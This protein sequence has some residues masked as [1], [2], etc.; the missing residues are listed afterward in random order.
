LLFS[1]GLAMASTLMCGL[2]PALS[3][4]RPHLTATTRTTAGVE[5]RRAHHLLLAAQIA[6]TVLLL[7]GTGAAV[8]ELIGLYRTSLGYDPHNVVI[9]GITLPDRSAPT[10][11]HTEWAERATFYERLRN[12][13]ADVP[14]V[15]SVALATYGIPPQSGER[16]EVEVPGRGM[17][18]D[19][20]PI[21]Q[22]ISGRYFATMRIPLVRGRVW[23]DSEGAGTPHVAVIN[24][25]MARARWPDES[26]IG[27]RVRIPDYIKSPTYFRLAAPGSDGWF[28]II[29]VVGDTPNVGLHEPPAPSI[30]VPYTLM[31]GDAVNVILRTSRD[32]L[33]MTRSIRE[34]VRS[35]DPNQPVSV[36]STAE[37]ELAS[38]GWAR[39]RFVTWLLL[40]FAAFAL[41]LAVVG[42]YSVVSYSVSCRSREFAIRMALGAGRGRIVNAAVQ[43]AVLAIVAGVIAGLTLSVGLGAVVARWSI[44][45]LTDPVVLVAVS[46]VLFVVTLMSAAMPAN[47]AASIRPADAL[48]ID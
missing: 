9:A 16:A 47:R 32:P 12:R 5:N 24:Q 23:S 38:A 29:G 4:S 44:G 43:P 39:E 34:A 28:E 27:R 31:L 46:L 36:V 11:S 20:A 2:S 7:A 14:Q 40:G 33:S 35:V 42:L 26:A 1:A 6:L 45:N 30:Y 48:R 15:Q 25:A 41:M 19:E 13:M 37:D 8:R 17:T 10:T 21:V 18:G 3:F 22:R